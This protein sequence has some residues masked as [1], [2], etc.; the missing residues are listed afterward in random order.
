METSGDTTGALGAAARRLLEKFGGQNPGGFTDTEL[1][2]VRFFYTDRASNR[3]PLHYAPGLAII[4]AGKKI[5]Y[6]DGRRF[7]YGAGS[8]L[9]VGLP[10]VFECETQAS[11][12]HPLFGLFI[13][14]SPTTLAE[15]SAVVPPR[16]EP[17]AP[18]STRQGVE[19]LR[20]QPSMGDA[21][22]RLI[23]QLCTPPQAQA[24]GEGTIREI[25]FHA[26]ND[27]HGRV[28][29][30]LTQVGK[31]EARIADLLR[32]VENQ[33]ERGLDTQ[34]MARHARMS[35]ATLHRY[36]RSVTGHSPG[37]YFKRQK[38]MRAR[39]LLCAQ[40]LTVAQTAHALGYGDPTNFSRDYRKLFGHPPSRDRRRSAE[41]T[42]E[43]RKR[44]CQRQQSIRCQE[45]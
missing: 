21:I 23:G 9:A 1:P 19:P 18:V 35:P 30:A 5:G 11:A 12:E 22:V 40:G 4:L 7:E 32:W 6:L 33:G 28:L 43:D 2:Q 17:E 3:E 8:Y 39:G 15:L 31:P 34:T 20:V 29:V 26:L 10:L 45:E 14:L 16:L 25:H 36:F 42:A 37:H 44:I 27:L 13:S 24:L 38:L 41:E